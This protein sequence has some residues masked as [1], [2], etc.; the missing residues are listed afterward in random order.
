MVRR[1]SGAGLAAADGLA[2]G[3]ADSTL[4]G[5]GAGSEA[6]GR[7]VAADEGSGVGEP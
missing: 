4:D 6:L 7:V 5:D 3:L 1:R 2:D